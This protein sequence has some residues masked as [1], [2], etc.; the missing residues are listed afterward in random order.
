MFSCP[1]PIVAAAAALLVAASGAPCAATAAAAVA[2]SKTKPS[3]IF[4]LTDDQDALLNGY[5]PAVGV[6]HMAQL[7]S[8]VR[9]KGALFTNYYLAYPLCSP[10]RAAILTGTFP[11]NHGLT[12]NGRLNTSTFHPVAEAR[13]VNTWLQAGGY[14]TMLC[15]KYMNGY[16]ANNVNKAAQYVP[17]GWSSFFGFQTVA[18]FGTAVRD[19]P[20]GVHA[21]S[22][23]YPK[24]NYQTDIISNITLDWMRSTRNRSLPFFLFLTPHAPHS[25]Y[26]PAPRHKGTLAGLTQPPDPSFNLPSGLQS[27]LPGNL[28]TLPLVDPEQ[29]DTIYESR[30]EALLAID[31]MIGHL[32]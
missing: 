18:F 13:T 28:G 2:G 12:D 25:P 9:S 5:D 11:H 10:S 8:R 30:A 7:N 16:H 14:E 6:N 3:I 26:T 32:L 1:C 15:G 20:D 17:P 23:V 31:E 22:K 21:T 29:M 4:V 27:R 19:A 24:D